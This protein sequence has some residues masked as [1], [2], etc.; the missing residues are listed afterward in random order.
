M[1]TGAIIATAGKRSSPGSFKPM[2]QIGSVSAVHRLIDT[3]EQV[4]VSP[5][6]LVADRHSHDLEKHLSRLGTVTLY[7]EDDEHCEMIDFVKIGLTYIEDKCD[8]VFITPVDV[9]L[10][11]AETVQILMRANAQ[12][13]SPVFNGRVGHPLLISGKLIPAF[14]QYKGENGLRGMIRNGG[15]SRTLIE[16]EDEGVLWDVDSDEDCRELLKRYNRQNLH[17]T[18]KICLA[19]EQTFFGP[20]SAQL[21][22]FIRETGSVRLACRQMAVSYSK[23]WKIIKMM[24]DQLGF[25]VVQRQQGGKN[26]GNACLTPRGQRILDKFR[27]YEDTC[28]VIIQ[29]V[30]EDTFLND[31]DWK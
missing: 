13:A 16:V 5:I 28:R 17:P 3:F 22:T 20:G 27:T 10:F 18:V 6:V 29:K 4:G 14:L 23:G 9:P 26:G 1:K 21:L 19:K 12:I 11:T 8:Q 7:N 31:D 30:F 2:I 25:E 24:E 15:F